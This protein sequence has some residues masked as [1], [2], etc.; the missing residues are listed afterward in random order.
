MLRWRLQFLNTSGV[1]EKCSVPGSIDRDWVCQKQTRNQML[2][3][4][5]LSLGRSG[6][7]P[8][9]GAFKQRSGCFISF[10]PPLWGD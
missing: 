9:P 4:N 1:A 2:A 6:A 3:H 5:L 7:V 10:L 8:K